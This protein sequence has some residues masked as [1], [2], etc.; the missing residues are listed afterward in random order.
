MRDQKKITQSALELGKK[1]SQLEAERWA[2]EEMKRAIQLQDI[3]QER[4]ACFFFNLWCSTLTFC[5]L[6]HQHHHHHH[7]LNNQ[8]LP[9]NLQTDHV[10]EK[11]GGWAQLP[12][13]IDNINNINKKKNYAS[14]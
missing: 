6:V 2:F 10:K 13:I 5:F 9:L 12:P 1:R 7:L 3:L 8:H 11:V 14:V 4:F